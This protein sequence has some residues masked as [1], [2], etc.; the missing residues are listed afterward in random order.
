MKLTSHAAWKLIYSK[1]SIYFSYNTRFLSKIYLKLLN[2][3]IHYSSGFQENEEQ[4]NCPKMRQLFP[5]RSERRRNE[6]QP[7]QTTRGMEPPFY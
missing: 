5:W 3:K 2:F 1:F 7:D 4:C 6:G